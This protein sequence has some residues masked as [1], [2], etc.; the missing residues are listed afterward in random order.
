MSL[1][2]QRIKNIY[3]AS[4]AVITVVIILLAISVSKSQKKYETGKLIAV[5][6]SRGLIKMNATEVAKELSNIYANLSRHSGY[7]RTSKYDIEI[8]AILD[9][10]KIFIEKNPQTKN[11]KA[12]DKKVRIINKT[13]ID[14]INSAN[15]YD[16]VMSHVDIEAQDNLIQ[17][18]NLLQHMDIL[19]QMLQ[20]DICDCGLLDITAFK[21]IEHK[22]DADI[23]DQIIDIDRTIDGTLN[24][25]TLA[26]EVVARADPYIIPRLPLFATQQSQIEGLKVEAQIRKPP[27]VNESQYLRGPQNIR[28]AQQRSQ[29]FR[30]NSKKLGTTHYID[31][32]LLFTPTYDS[33]AL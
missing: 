15:A 19:I 7:D 3:M 31:E 30:E 16:S 28:N 4:I 14:K 2:S 12:I 10:V 32:D 21:N 27:I 24:D 33:M 26:T 22:L 6:T 20:Q 8:N 25:P 1:D 5:K 18:D 29:M 23:A 17:L 9:H 11:P 13:S